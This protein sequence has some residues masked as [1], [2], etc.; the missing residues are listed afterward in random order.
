M[1]IQDLQAQMAEAISKND[2]AAMENVASQIVAGKKDRAKAE[3]EQLQKEAEQLAGKREDTA[4]KIFEL[5]NVNEGIKSMLKEV[6]ARGFNFYIKTSYAVP[7]EPE[8]HQQA[9]CGLIL[10][11]AVKARAV[12]TS[13]TGKSKDEFGLSLGEIFEKF[14]TAEDRIKLAAATTGS[15]QWQVKVAVKKA[16]IAAGKL[17][18][19]K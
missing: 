18:P 8:V 1:S 13:S 15:S 2:V 5:L 10:V 9:S 6:K 11:Q 4:A 16:A 3:A 14:A 19:V 7:G 17:A 12:G